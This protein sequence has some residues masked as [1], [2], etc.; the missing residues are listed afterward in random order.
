MAKRLWTGLLI[1]LALSGVAFLNSQAAVSSHE[2]KSASVS[3]SESIEQLTQQDRVVSYLREHQRLPD[4]YITKKQARAEGWD[5]SAGNLCSAVPGRAIGG[6]RFS[7][8]EKRLPQKAKR[9]W[10][11]AD[12]NYH[13][14]R[15]QA[16]RLI[17]SNDG[18]IYITRDHYRTFTKME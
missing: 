1:I 18:L 12:I 2:G 7:N 8:R 17:Y 11:E 15:R 4:F 13:C 9:V 5:A 10:R 6:D 3:T 14:G 16:D